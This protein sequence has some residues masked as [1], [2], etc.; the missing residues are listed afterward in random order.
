VVSLRRVHVVSPHFRPISGESIEQTYGTI[1]E[2]HAFLGLTSTV[3]TGDDGII[4]F[5]FGCFYH[6]KSFSL[7]NEKNLPLTQELLLEQK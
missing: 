3:H 5:Y 7:L 4:I 1:V 2:Q 6:F